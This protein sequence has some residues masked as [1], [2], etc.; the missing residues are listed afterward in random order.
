MVCER[1]NPGN[2]VEH[3]SGWGSGPSCDRFQIVGTKGFAP[4]S[5]ATTNNVMEL[6]LCQAEALMG[7]KLQVSDRARARPAEDI[8]PPLI[9]HQLP[10]W[11]EGF[12]L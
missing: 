12:I 2:A 5:G 4:K 10:D 9:L 1:R 11:I 8:G 7:L 6:G 3:P